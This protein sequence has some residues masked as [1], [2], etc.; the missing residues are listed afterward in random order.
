MLYTDIKYIL[1]HNP[2]YPIYSNE[3]T[4]DVPEKSAHDHK[5]ISLPEGLYNIGHSGAGSSFDNE[6]AMD[7]VYLHGFDI[8]ASLVTTGDY[9][10]FM[11]D[12]GYHNHRFWHAEGWDWVMDQQVEA[13]LYFVEHDGQWMRFSLSGLRALNPDEPIVHVNYYEAA[14]Y[15]SWAGMRLPTEFEWEAASSQFGWGQLWEWTGSA[16]LPYPGF[17]AGP[18]AVARVRRRGVGL[19]APSVDAE[20]GDA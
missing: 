5:W 14:A 9:L 18:G 3:S 11:K 15:A 20:F 16:Y 19:P 12:G 13:P 2:L 17:A 8:A 10:A 4:V 6:L 7:L 1:G